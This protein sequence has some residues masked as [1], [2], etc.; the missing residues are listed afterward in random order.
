[1]ARTDRGGVKAGRNGNLTWAHQKS[2]LKLVNRRQTWPGKTRASLMATRE[3]AE[4]Y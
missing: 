4:T 3:D 2:V 1:V